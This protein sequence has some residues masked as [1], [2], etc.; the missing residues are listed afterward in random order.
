[1][2]QNMNGAVPGSLQFVHGQ[3]NIDGQPINTNVAPTQPRQLRTGETLATANGSADIL[4]APGALLR[5]GGDTT[6][7]MVAGDPGRTEVRLEQGTA[8][9]SVNLVRDHDLLL[10]DMP[11]GQTQMLSPR[12]VYLQQQYQYHARLQW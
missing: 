6:V 10:L 12:P 7:N 5:I 8:N 4:L 3:A 2:A 11:N 9:I 1:M